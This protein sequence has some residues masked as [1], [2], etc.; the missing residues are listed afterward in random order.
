MI[1][2]K[3]H[4]RE[5]IFIKKKK[6]LNGHKKMLVLDLFLHFELLQHTKSVLDNLLSQLAKVGRKCIDNGHNFSS[7]LDPVLNKKEK[8][9]KQSQERIL[10]KELFLSRKNIQKQIFHVDT[11]RTYLLGSKSCENF[12]CG[13]FK[14]LRS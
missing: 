4:S 10:S 5:K 13:L 6:Y 9:A 2:I 7:Q 11:I 12:F 3:Q 8:L 14:E 1:I